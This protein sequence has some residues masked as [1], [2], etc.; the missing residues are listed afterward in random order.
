MCLAYSKMRNLDE[1]P[2]S[3]EEAEVAKYLMELTGIGGG[4]DPIGSLIA[5]HRELVRQRAVLSAK[6][7]EIF[8]RI[9]FDE[10]R[11]E[12]KMRRNVPSQ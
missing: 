7:P 6:H 5:S 4:D 12:R 9:T 8:K 11:S 1:K 10:L 2:Y 3:R